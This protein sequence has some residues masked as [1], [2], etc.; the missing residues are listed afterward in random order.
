[1]FTSTPPQHKTRALNNREYIPLCRGVHVCSDLSRQRASNR[2]QCELRD[3]HMD[4]TE[5]IEQIRSKCLETKEKLFKAQSAVAAYEN[6]LAELEQ[7][8][9][10]HIEIEMKVLCW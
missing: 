8:L 5:D 10:R 9:L 7:K 1:M 6:E 3:H 4:N 2:H